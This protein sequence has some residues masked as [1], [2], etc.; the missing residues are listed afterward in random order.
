MPS[1]AFIKIVNSI[2]T[3]G[4]YAFNPLT[5]AKSDIRT[6]INIMN[7]YHIQITGYHNRYTMMPKENGKYDNKSEHTAIVIELERLKI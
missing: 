1:K 6:I 3:T 4:E 7:D 5:I 2:L